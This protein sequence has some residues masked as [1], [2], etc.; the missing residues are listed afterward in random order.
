MGQ[1]KYVFYRLSAGTLSQIEIAFLTFVK[2]N[3]LHVLSLYNTRF[4]IHFYG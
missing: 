4:L 3:F 1:L 2:L